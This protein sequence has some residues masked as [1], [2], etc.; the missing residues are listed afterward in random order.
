MI[1][2]V[3]SALWASVASDRKLLKPEVSEKEVNLI[4]RA[5]TPSLGFYLV[6]IGLAFVAPTVAAFGYLVIAI[7]AVLRARGDSAP[8]PT[9]AGSV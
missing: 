1:S 6:V 7:V 9:G 8:T 4:A 3:F 2:L 5:T